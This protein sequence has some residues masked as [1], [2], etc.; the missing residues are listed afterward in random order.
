MDPQLF[1][2]GIA[3]LGLALFLSHPADEDHGENSGI[4]L[5]LLPVWN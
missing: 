4:Q 1:A 3:L 5:I 2:A